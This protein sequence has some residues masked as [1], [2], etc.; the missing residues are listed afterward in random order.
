M[1]IGLPNALCEV[2]SSFSLAFSENRDW[3]L[4]SDSGVPNGDEPLD[5]AGKGAVGAS[6][7]AV[8]G[9]EFAISK[10]PLSVESG[11]SL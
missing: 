8:F 5:V 3:T 10:G 2:S 6:D 7:S 11:D 4:P 1:G 9:A